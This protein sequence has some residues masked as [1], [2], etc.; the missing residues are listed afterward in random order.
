MS[1]LFVTLT[2][3][4]PARGVT[5]G[6]RPCHARSETEEAIM[7]II[8]DILHAWGLERYGFPD[9]DGIASETLRN[10]IDTDQELLGRLFIESLDEEFP[11]NIIE[12]QVF[13][14]KFTTARSVDDC[15]DR[16]PDETDEDVEEVAPLS[17]DAR[18]LLHQAGDNDTLKALILACGR[19]RTDDG[20]HE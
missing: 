9:L 8:I 5:S 17:A 2:D 3:P 12:F 16:F 18:V 7:G 4:S 1:K 13:E 14:I 6:P 11:G 20:S 19:A 10:L 15:L